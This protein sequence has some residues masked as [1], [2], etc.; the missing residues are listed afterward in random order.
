MVSD[1]L[2]RT[3]SFSYGATGLL[4]LVADGTRSVSFSYTGGLLT[5]ATD[6][7]G[8]TWSFAYQSVGALIGLLTGVTE[9]L[10]NTPVTQTYD[11]LGRVSMQQDALGHSSSYAYDVPAAGCVYHDGLGNPW[12]Y[13]HDA[14]GRLSMLTDPVGNPT[15]YSYDPQ[16]RPSMLMR[17][18]GDVTSYMYDPASGYP[19]MVGLADGSAINWVYGSHSVG[20][21]MLFD[22]A[23]AGYAD[24]TSE[25]YVRDSAGNPTDFTDQS[26]A[27]WMRTYNSRGQVLTATNPTGGVTTFTYDPLG[28]PA[29]GK[30]NAGNMASFTY[31]PLNR[32]T[33]VA[34]PDATHRN[35]AYDNLDALT[36]ITDERGKV[37]GDSYD[38]DERL[39]SEAD[40]LGEA[41]GF[42]YDDL[43]RVT[44]RVDP[45]G[46]ATLYAFDPAGRLMSVTDRSGRTTSYQYDT[47]GRLAGIVDPAGGTTAY[48]YD[49]DSR[50]PAVQD[51]LMHTIGYGYDSMDRVTHLTDPVGTGFDYAYDAM[52]RL[53]TAN[54]PL[55]RSQTF[56]YEPRGLLDT[57]FDVTSETDAPRTPLGEVSQITDPN[58]HAWTRNYDPQGRLTSDADPLTRSTSVSY[59]ALSRPVHV[60]RPDG[61]VQQIDYD[62][63]G[64]IMGESFTDGTSFTYTYDDANRL[65]GATGASFGYD[66]AGRMTA[67]NGFTMT[68]DNEG[69]ILSETLAPGKIVTYAYDDRGLPSQVMD[70]MGG[71]TSFTYDAADRLIGVIRPNGTSGAYQYDAANRLTSAVERQPGPTGTP[72]SS[73]SITRDALG[74]PTSIDRRQPLM[75]GETMPGS[76]SLTYDPASQVNG[77]GHDA[78][79][80][81]TGDASRTF[82]WDAAS[83][84]THYAAGAD[85]PRFTFDAFGSALTSTQGSRTVQQA[86]NYWRGVPDMDDTQVNLPV[87]RTSYYVHAPSGL[88]LYSVDGSSG[89]RRF[90]HYDEAGNTIVLTNDA[91][92]V[93]AG[94]A[95]APYGGGRAIG[96]TDDNP[97]TVEAAEG[98]MKLGSSGLVD[99]GHGIYDTVSMRIISELTPQSGPGC[100]PSPSDRPKESVSLDY[101]K[102]EYK[103]VSMGGTTLHELGHNYRLSHGGGSSGSEPPRSWES[104][105]TVPNVGTTIAVNDDMPVPIPPW[106]FVQRLASASG[107]GFGMVKS[108]GHHLGSE[109]FGGG[110]DYGLGSSTSG[111]VVGDDGISDTWETSGVADERG[112]RV[113]GVDQ[114]CNGVFDDR[115]AGN[116]DPRRSLGRRYAIFGHDVTCVLPSPPDEVFVGSH[117]RIKVQFHWNR[118]GAKDP[119]PDRWIR[120]SKLGSIRPAALRPKSAGR[121]GGVAVEPYDASPWRV[122][123]WWAE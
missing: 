73:I 6:A 85:S 31:D 57:Y 106:Y 71:M 117:D 87:P 25:S 9:P 10:G 24:G 16:G 26:G 94:Y 40:P 76:T 20:G 37:W 34:W 93:I 38:S 7:A 109:G 68:Y 17:P 36:S 121:G 5:G 64:R 58:R 32:L 47:V 103:N 123:P 82:Q 113:L 27:H 80:R 53:R 23:A 28:R 44:Q 89:A 4:I 63:A 14:Q 46:H 22:L 119:S 30:D 1:G 98:A 108:D 8:H 19:S 91:G 42:A 114:D 95:Y 54:A 115:G 69:R 107:T 72:I 83:R 112:V 18:M 88:L 65:T 120:S 3:L 67:C 15:S 12:T 41:T 45:L 78:L 66:A 105:Q 11:P 55:G 122:P 43:D 39:T 110:Y 97:F 102:V 116:F 2:G 111:S 84:L 81:T 70:W 77:V 96:E 29:T 56:H 35:F 86:W 49:A 74:Q 101:T 118:I 62:P 100:G 79:G 50:V 48:S 90:Y 60:G 13:L 21:A 59:D 99:T 33:Q 92:S 51:A 61:T 75:P 104:P 52:G